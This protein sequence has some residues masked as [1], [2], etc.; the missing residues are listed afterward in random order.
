MSIQNGRYYA[1]NAVAS[2]IWRKL[3]QPTTADR[4]SASL[5]EEYKG[6]RG[7]IASDLRE[8]LEEWLTHRLIE[9]HTVHP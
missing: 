1:L 8:T 4:L 7:R 9:A 6:D 2:E 5:A 3:E